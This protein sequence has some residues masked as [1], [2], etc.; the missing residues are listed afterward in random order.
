[1]HGETRNIGSRVA[2]SFQIEEEEVFV[3]IPDDDVFDIQD[4]ITLEA[5]IYPNV[6]TGNTLYRAIA[7]KYD[8]AED[9]RAY[10]LSINAWSGG[11]VEFWVSSDGDVRDS[12]E[13]P[14]KGGVWQHVAG[15]YDGDEL[16]IF[17]NGEKKASKETDI[18]TINTNE[19]PFIIGSDN[20]F[21]RFWRGEIYEVRLWNRARSGVEIRETMH[22]RL[23]G[24]DDGLVGYWPLNEGVGCLAHDKS[25]NE[26][27]GELKPDCPEESPEWVLR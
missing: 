26:N 18:S 19:E 12:V 8:T 21:W 14:F 25:T 4:E 16:K 1:M 27:H 13:Y 11:E 17:I 22:K 23:S 3:E 9:E 5:W 24:K 6:D 10:Q 7:G 15:V 2:L 20:V